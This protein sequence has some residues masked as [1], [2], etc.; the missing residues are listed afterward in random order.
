MLAILC[1]FLISLLSLYL[2]ITILYLLTIAVLS[3]FIKE[4]KP[5]ENKPNNT[6]A[7]LV[8]AHNESLLISFL[9]KSLLQIDYPKDKYTVFVIADNCNDDTAS[10]STQFPVTVLERYDPHNSGKGQAL[11]W[12]LQKI[13][14]NHY[15]AVLIVDADNYVDSGILIELTLGR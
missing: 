7:I 3:Y 11:A 10:K 8:P 14:L 6:F 1:E 4:K 9:C 2:L 13:D 12:A 5:C 15:N